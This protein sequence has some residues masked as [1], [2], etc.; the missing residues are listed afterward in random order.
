M[1]DRIAAE[2]STPVHTLGRQYRLFV[3]DRNCGKYFLVDSGADLSVIPVEKSQKGQPP[4]FNLYAANGSQIKTYGSKLL[5]IDLG[6]KRNFEWPFI[7]ADVSKGILGAD[8]LHHYGL[9]VDLKN[10]K[11]ID[12]TTKLKI[13]AE[14]TTV[15]ANESVSSLYATCQFSKLLENFPDL[16]KPSIVPKVL[17]H[18]VQH[19][20]TTSPGPP[21]YCKAHRLDPHKLKIAKQEFQFLL[22][23]GII[24]PSK[25]QWASP[26]HLAKNP[27]GQW[28]VCEDYR[29]LNDR[30]LP[31]RYPI[32]K[33]DDV[34]FMLQ[35]KNIF[36]KVDL[37]KAYY[38]IPLAEEDKLKSAIITPFGLYEFN[39]MP[40]GLRNAPSTF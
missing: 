37:L 35:N 36:S 20:I 25:S 29:R 6:L 10:K 22:N 18:N 9:L 4:D 21:V 15:D 26:L 39:Y 31:D 16:T 8:F 12:N 30:T 38:Q 24:R 27:S 3:K 32:P 17:K 1:V 33:I 13:V 28:R 5:N 40:F 11:L 23:N 34:N 7:V 14:V 2:C 19:Y